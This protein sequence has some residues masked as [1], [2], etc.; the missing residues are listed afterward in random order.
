MTQRFDDWSTTAGNNTTVG[1]GAIDI[2]ENMAPGNINNA[3]RDIMAAAALSFGGFPEGTSRPSIVAAGS[4]W[5]DTTTA[6]APIVKLYDGTD[7][8]TVFTFNYTANTVSFTLGALSVDTAELAAEAVTTAKIAASAVTATEIASSAVTTAKIAAN[9]VTAAK[10]AADTITAA[11]IAAS[12]IAASELASSAVTSAKIAS[13][14]VTTAKIA[15]DAVT[16]VKIDSTI[17]T[18]SD[19]K[20]VTGTAGTTNFTP[21]W[22]AN[23]DIIDGFEVLDEDDMSSNSATKLASQQSIKAYVDA[24][25]LATAFTSSEQTITAAGALTL[26]H[27][28]GAAPGLVQA[29]L[30]C[31]TDDIGYSSGDEVIVNNCLSS[32]NSTGQSLVMDATNVNVR[33]GS[34]SQTYQ[35]VRK[36]NGASAAITNANWKLKIRAWV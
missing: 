3:M 15:T 8:I 36:N 9:A 11:E 2:A 33:F 25:P 1:S 27:S 5:L 30:V 12:A 26:A 22:D 31:Q 23:G 29:S 14:A 35:L 4:M 7:D 34:E 13:S 20:L 18:G 6:T 10:I 32:G 24:E 28:L 16:R 17:L 21:K 19:A